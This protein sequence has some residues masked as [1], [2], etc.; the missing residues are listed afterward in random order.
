MA[1]GDA[2]LF[3]LLSGGVDSLVALQ[4][5][6]K[7]VGAERVRSVHVDTGLMRLG[8]SDAIV[9]HLADAGVQGVEVGRAEERFLNA[10]R[11]VA[12]PERK[13]GIIG[14]LFVDVLQDALKGE[15]LGGGWKLVQGTIFPDTIESGDGRGAPAVKT[16]HNRV[17][18]IQ[19]MIEQ[20]L[21]IEPLRELYKDQVRQLG[22]MLGLPESLVNRHPFPGPGLGIRLLCHDGAA[23][24]A[25]LPEIRELQDALSTMGM[26]AQVL[27]VKS[28]GVERGARSYRHPVVVWGEGGRLPQWDVLQRKVPEWIANTPGINRIVVTAD[29]RKPAELSARET[30]VTREGLE[31]LRKVDAHLQ[32]RIVHLPGL[33]QAPVVALPLYDAQG[34]QAFVLRAISSTNAMTADVVPVPWDLLVAMA[35]EIRS[36][37]G[38]GPLFYDV[39]PK[40]PGTIEW[41]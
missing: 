19:D 5:C 37:N 12:D 40:P 11:G 13:R 25:V 39:T 14:R 18:V 27:P 29:G 4:V 28:V 20:G 21:V 26:N 10:L 2:S 17:A 36:I 31:R 32:Q 34:R 38:I 6:L 1:A 7:A 3:L 33:W 24:D 9:R 35:E 23:E 16:H 8:A 22:L 30:F 41:E 15:R